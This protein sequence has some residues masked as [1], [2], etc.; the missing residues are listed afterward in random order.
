MMR[1][2]A[3]DTLAADRRG[4]Q[5]L[6]RSMVSAIA[7]ATMLA[8]PLRTP[9][10]A[11]G[12][13]GTG[14]ARFGADIGANDQITINGS[15]AVIDWAVPTQGGS[16]PVDFLPQGQTVTFDGETNYTVL[17]RVFVTGEAGR[18][19]AI[20]GTVNSLVGT[21][22]QVPGGAVWFY[23][24][25]GILVGGTAT[26][27]VGSLLL[28]TGDPSTSGGDSLNP[29]GTFTMN[30][31]GA[32]NG[33]R[34]SS[35]ATINAT[36]V[37]NGNGNYVAIVSPIVE[38]SGT[39]NVNGTAAYVA[40]ESVDLR[41]ND[42]LFDIVINTGSDTAVEHDGTTQWQNSSNDEINR[43]V[44]LVSVPKNDAITMALAPGKLGFDTAVSA[45]R[46]DD[47]SI[48]LSA[49]YNIDGGAL[50]TLADA[51]NASIKIDGGAFNANVSAKA[52]YDTIAASTTSTAKFAGDVSLFGRHSARI[53][54]RENGVTMTIGGDLIVDSSVESTGSPVIGGMASAL[55][56]N[57]GTLS[58]AGSLNVR[59]NASG[60]VDDGQGSFSVVAATGG[61]ATV[62]ADGGSITANSLLISAQAQVLG[63]DGGPETPFNAAP[64]TGGTANLLVS[65]NGSVSTPGNL[66]MLTTAVAVAGDGNGGIGTGGTI[67]LNLADN[68]GLAVGG[69][70]ALNASGTGADSTSGH[71]S[72]GK[73]GNISIHFADSADATFTNRLDVLA[74]GR[75]GNG[76]A[77]EGGVDGGAGEGGTIGV[78]IGGNSSLT[79]NAGAFFEANGYGGEGF[80]FEGATGAGGAGTGGNVN[81]EA[82]GGTLNVSLRLS[83]AAVSVGGYGP[84][85]GNAIAVAETQNA[86]AKG[87]VRL[88]A[89]AG[90]SVNQSSGQG[91][92]SVVLL[93]SSTAGAGYAG[94]AGNATGGFATLAAESGSINA[95]NSVT[96][97]VGAFIDSIVEGPAGGG[98]ATG[99][100]A[101]IFASGDGSLDLDSLD[102]Y[103][104]AS[105]GFNSR[106]GAGGSAS[107]GTISISTI[108]SG[109][110]FLGDTYL[111]ASAQGGS[112][113]TGAGGAATGGD[114]DLFVD[115]S[116][117][118]NSS[119]NLNFAG[120]LEANA[121]AEGGDGSLFDGTG[122]GGAGSGGT[123][124]F[125]TSSNGG[126]LDIGDRL[127]MTA[128]GEGGHSSGGMGGAG[129][130]GRVVL[131]GGGG[132]I[133]TRDGVAL[134]ANSTGGGGATQG[135]DAIAV[136]ETTVGTGRGFVQIGMGGTG[137]YTALGSE[138]LSLLARSVA[139]DA[140]S[141]D[142]GTA[143]GGTA[144]LGVN[145]SATIDVS[146]LM[147]V[148]ASV[149]AG[150]SE[151]SSGGGSATGGS[152]GIFADG[153][154][155]IYL[156][157]GYFGTATGTGGD[158]FGSADAGIGKGGTFSGSANGS[159]VLQIDDSTSID[160]SGFGGRS[161]SGDG[162]NGTGGTA[163][164]AAGSG[165]LTL[166]N[167]SITANGTG[168]E[169]YDLGGI[170]K[171][172]TAKLAVNAAGGSATAFTVGLTA[173]GQGGNT[174][175]YVPNEQD[176]N[177]GGAAE[178][179]IGGRGEG[180]LAQFY[181]GGGTLNISDGASANSNG[182]GGMG[183]TGGAGQ[184]GIP[185][186]FGPN[187]DL[188]G[189][190]V[191]VVSGSATF[192]GSEG[193]GIALVS[194][195]T[196]GQGRTDR[197]GLSGTAG[198]GTGGYVEMF[199]LNGTGPSTINASDAT[200]VAVGFGGIGASPSGFS[201]ADGG[202]GGVG[203]GGHVEVGGYAANSFINIG[204]TDVQTF[205]QGGLGGSGADG[206][207]GGD[208]GHGVGGTLSLGIVSGVTTTSNASVGNFG[209]VVIDVYGRG[210]S[211]GDGGFGTG[212]GQDGTGGAG[213]DGTGGAAAILARGRPVTIDSLNIDAYGEG[214][215]SGRTGNN[216]DSF[217][218]DGAGGS[219]VILSSYRADGSSTP[220]NLVLYNPLSSGQMSIGANPNGGSITADISGRSAT[221]GSSTAGHFQIG[222]AGGDI[223]IAGTTSIQ[224][225]GI[226]QPL[227]EFDDPI[228]SQVFAG[229]GEIVFGDDFFLSSSSQAGPINF[230]L[231]SGGEIAFN[232]SCTVNGTQCAAPEVRNPSPPPPPPPEITFNQP[233]QLSNATSGTP[234]SQ[235]LTVSHAS[236]PLTFEVTS[237]E[238]PPGITLS[239]SGLLSG[240]STAEV[241]TNYSFEITV[242]DASNNSAVMVFRLTVQPFAT[243][244]PPPPP[245][246]PPVVEE[247]SPP[248][249]PPPPVEEPSPPP[250][251]PPAPVEEPSPPP[252]PVV[253][254][255]EVVET[256]T[257]E[258]TKIT[259][260][261]QASLTGTRVAGGS[262][263]SSSGGGLT[264]GSTSGGSSGGSGS[265]ATGT[266][267]AASADSGDDSGPVADEGGDEESS[268]EATTESGGAAV[269]NPNVLV[270][271][272][273]VAGA[274]PQIDTP[275][276]STGNSSLWSG[277]DGLG[278]D[279]GGGG[280]IP[281]GG[282]AGGGGGAPGGGIASGGGNAPSGG[283]PSGGDVPG[284]GTPG[285]GDVP[286]AG[287]PSGG[288]SPSGG[289]GG[290]AGGG[291][292][293]GGGNAPAG[294]G[295]PAG[296][297]T[298]GGGIAA[299]GGTAPGSA[300]APGGDAAGGG[301][302]SNGGDA[303]AGSAAPGGNTPAGGIAP[304]GGS[305]SGDAAGADGTGGGSGSGGGNAPAGG[306]GPAG[307]IVGGNAGVGGDGAGGGDAPGAGGASGG[308]N[309][310]GGGAPAGGDL[311]GGGSTPG[312]SDT[313]GG[314]Q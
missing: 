75:G 285:G 107:G 81:V 209:E 147:S 163:N 42:G 221:G 151:G 275:I 135:G 106:S 279:I 225:F 80:N 257:M 160:V 112:A 94:S 30:T 110:N 148:S 291:G 176:S 133:I 108:S 158:S 310:A 262:I 211:G 210:G 218:G 284:G 142:A 84:S 22:S 121:W 306:V 150:D 229:A 120:S 266:A 131:Y 168:G 138:S 278:G 220:Q 289:L 238:L 5:P 281:A 297:D 63:L 249:P 298:P 60:L 164:L 232:G 7:I 134:N 45:S 89:N 137:A 159:A 193:G 27:N 186:G 207:N 204:R 124:D 241:S 182:Q 259:S 197:N 287:I 46:A 304:A 21:S 10:L 34:I 272:S 219:F 92:S 156:R 223:E 311:P 258:T 109:G 171:G 253:D 54:A 255:P 224:A 49:G 187:D 277:A 61:T 189:S 44:F 64:A 76:Y 28:T 113:A 162:A 165:T 91:T 239:S 88:A 260:S 38:Q 1:K 127:D 240:T 155:G 146:E 69:T 126:V 97:D 12:F 282:D 314:G 222:T 295:A 36:N 198:A 242:T 236:G 139:G 178:D 67:S 179:S 290:D 288:D 37:L 185:E 212:G 102:V 90:G 246:P 101:G 136:T 217:G 267:A 114:I 191:T 117:P 206:G 128:Y 35:G 104:D 256:V 96:L 196:G 85:G 2:V 56:E 161:G 252:P 286:G 145:G 13:V 73:G 237:G 86:L 70:T 18:D 254:V 280:D 118:N 248:P 302:T 58:V 243:V 180:G 309:A 129:T 140:N 50:G 20:R 174:A 71:G 215:S 24:P 301:S 276:T 57:G 122:M 152:L 230:F 8:I 26:F 87:S 312:S 293:P 43:R 59:A 98:N 77:S 19:I 265:A 268:E 68:G 283:I 141:G 40:A 62:Q 305:A 100:K 299:G 200:L 72:A 270:D 29:G 82:A 181:V 115:G 216:N 190:F 273:G 9:A 153:D 307:G 235:Q 177:L 31:T 203:T 14:T 227:D 173:N 233:E 116:F 303:P 244:P 195:G 79:A 201:G 78:V 130:G 132:T 123:I 105:G 226:N 3:F 313:P 166:G 125:G 93:A 167:I 296:G 247:P 188:F 119:A 6:Q 250:P 194:N 157:N 154:G 308:G 39:V 149:S 111:N 48:V 83:L 32:T 183:F 172:G 74:T 16:A 4:L 199:A 231:D 192:E 144:F 17:N 202:H 25:G 65:D 264:G 269:G 234:F 51:T 228:V 53:G 251:P 214:G 143:I 11:Q 292:I 170:G 274:A 213:G 99:G 15:T 300:I 271:T 103:A 33:V 294:A 47:G 66:S 41:I 261:I 95:Q 205:G 175:I 208:G 169:G 263:G 184:G 55:A 23:S 245:P 52:T